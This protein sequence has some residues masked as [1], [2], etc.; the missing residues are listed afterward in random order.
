ME[1][2]DYVAKALKSGE[3]QAVLR[4]SRTTRRT[5]RATCSSGAPTC[6]ARPAR[7][8]SISSSICSA[9][10]T[11]CM[12]KDLGEDGKKKPTEV[13]VARRGAGRK[14]RPAGHARLPHVDDLRLLRHRAADRDLVRE[15]RPQHLR[16]APV[17]PSAVGGGRSGRGKRAATGTSTRASPRRSREVAPEVLGVEKDVVLTPIMH[18]TP[19]EIAQPFDV[20]DWKRGEM[21]ADPRQDHAGGHGGRARLSRTSTSASPRSAR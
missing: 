17:H 12:G 4:R 14:A 13:V 21:R 5:G 18:D 1:P 3:L 6:S 19:G 20:K 8:T 9:P 16:H 7:A 2:K 10:S 11:A 15:E